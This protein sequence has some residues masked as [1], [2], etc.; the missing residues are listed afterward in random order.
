MS[1][2]NADRLTSSM[3]VKGRSGSTTGVRSPPHLAELK[4][5]GYG[6]YRSRFETESDNNE[7]VS[8]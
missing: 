5:S 4:A 1:Y 2:D 8:R 3:V 7:E 6:D